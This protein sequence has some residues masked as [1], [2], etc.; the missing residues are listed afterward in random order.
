M[1]LQVLV[2]LFALFAFSRALLRFKDKEITWKEFLFWVV[3]WVGVIVLAIVPDI[4][5]S[6]SNL[7]GIGRGVDLIIYTSIIALFYL[8]FRLYVKLEVIEQN[9]TKITRE[10]AFGNRNERGS[11]RKNKKMR[12]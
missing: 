5:S 4:S 12:K 2:V 7:L 1:L 9:I 10:I 11:K 3:V 8:I 6:L